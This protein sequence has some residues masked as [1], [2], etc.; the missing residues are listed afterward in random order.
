MELENKKYWL[1]LY[2]L[3]TGVSFDILF[4]DKTL[5]ISCLIFTILTIIIFL[6]SFRGSLKKLNN[7]MWLLAI[8]ILLLSATFFI[9]SNQM[10]NILN[11]LIVPVLVIMLGVLVTG[12]NK[13]NWPDIRFTGDIAKRIFVPLF[14]IHK[15]FMALSRMDTS[16]NKEGR[17]RV[18]PKVLLGI[19]ISVPIL[20]LI[21]WLL[22]SADIIF[23]DLFLNIPVSKI[24]KHFLLIIIISVYAT[25]FLW[26]LVKAYDEKE[27]QKYGKIKWKL[28]FDPVILI[29]ILVLIN[30]IYTIFS[31]I[32]F[33]Y[34]F[35][36]SSFVLPS[37]YTYAEYARKGFFE[38]VVVSIINFGILILGKTFVKKDNKRI[39]TTI[40]ILL[41]LFVIFTLILLASAFYRMLVYEQAYGF[42]YLRIFVQT[43]MI[44]LFF[45][46]IANIIYIWRPNFPVIKSYFI[47]SLTIY[48][49]MN[50]AN[51][52]VIIAE[53]NI[54]RYFESG[55]IDIY[56]LKELSYDAIPGMQRFLTSDSYSSD[57]EKKK[58]TGE[59]LEQFKQNKFELESQKSWQSFNISRYSAEKIIDKYID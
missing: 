27:G 54:D 1:L 24:I 8:P 5:G 33:T 46:S 4:Y 21:I 15:P 55:Q 47:I 48:I 16:G 19:L 26:S 31:A 12:V 18:L 9:Y 40:R 39:F 52:D 13:S 32:Q 22:S 14:F 29:T 57:L 25:C 43:F 44:M 3:I 36:G 53:N 34:L 35:G 28:F 41:N 30:I 58:I 45:L 50:F 10:L 20:A 17:S 51:V 56:Y 23:K 6:L 2:G 38:L 7:I 49:M 42:T 59:I 11:F 37:S